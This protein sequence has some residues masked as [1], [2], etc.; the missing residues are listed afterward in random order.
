MFKKYPESPYYYILNFSF[1][2]LLFSFFFW[3]IKKCPVVSYYS[4]LIF[5][6][7]L[8]FKKYPNILDYFAFSLVISGLF[9]IT[10]CLINS[11]RQFLMIGLIFFISRSSLSFKSLYLFAL[12][13]LPFNICCKY[14][15]LNIFI[16]TA[17]VSI[18]IY[19]RKIFLKVYENKNFVFKW[20][21]INLKI[22]L[23]PGFSVLIYIYHNLLKNIGKQIL[24]FKLFCYSDFPFLHI[25]TKVY[26]KIYENK[27][28]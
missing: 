24:Y 16:L 26:W 15:S 22:F 4:V 18:L 11:S 10:F 23:L 19:S 12:K 1:I 8:C 13:N 6:F 3:S 17:W 21:L 14:F 27:V 7:F 28:L 9:L 25:F 2:L 5:L 20:F